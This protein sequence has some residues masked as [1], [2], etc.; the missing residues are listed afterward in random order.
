M[1]IRVD[2]NST[3]PEETV[4]TIQCREIDDSL[5]RVISYLHTQSNAVEVTQENLV[6]HI[7]LDDIFY[8]E[9]VDNK[10][11]L[12]TQSDVYETPQKLYEL[13]ERLKDTLFLRINKSTIL[14]LDKLERVKVLLN[15]K[16]EASLLNGEKV[17]ITRHYLSDFKKKLG[18]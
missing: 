5:A 4:V 15:A 16:Y 13:E 14:N 10:T 17:I 8:F 18:V 9:S 7:P 6:K 11:Y 2:E 12:Y 3:H 1:K